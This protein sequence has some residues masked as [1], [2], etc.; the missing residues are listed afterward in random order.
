M[1]QADHSSRVVPTVVC[2]C[3]WSRNLKHEEVLALVGLQCQ[4]EEK[5]K[6]FRF[7]V[8]DLNYYSS[9]K[10]PQMIIYKHITC[11]IIMV[12]TFM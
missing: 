1:R 11:R 10:F 4:R 2:R 9:V 6:R 3:V 8:W 7:M 12:I 5:I